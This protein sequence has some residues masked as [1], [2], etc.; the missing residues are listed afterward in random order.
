VEGATTVGPQLIG[1][2]STQLVLEF[3]PPS[4]KK[5]QYD[6]TAYNGGAGFNAS[7]DFIPWIYGAD[8]AGLT[9][10]FVSA[11]LMNG[12]GV[13]LLGTTSTGSEDMPVNT[14]PK[15]GFRFNT[16]S[17]LTGVGTFD[18]FRFTYNLV[19]ASN[20]SMSLGSQYVD[21]YN[22]T[23]PIMLAYQAGLPQDLGPFLTLVAVPEPSTY[24]MA[25]AG[26]ACGGYSM[27]RR[28]KRA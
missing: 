22:P 26:L 25:L 13:S 17:A 2:G 18:G 23:P 14:T 15:V 1:S 19:N 28:R 6:S 16:S 20:Q 27:F 10:A 21:I 3:R 5:F 11:E 7:L 9:G 24:A 8:P 4:G 12:S